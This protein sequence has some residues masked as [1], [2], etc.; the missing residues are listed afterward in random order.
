MNIENLVNKYGNKLN[1]G[2][3]EVDSTELYSDLLDMKDKTSEDEFKYKDT[4]CMLLSMIEHGYNPHSFYDTDI[5]ANAKR[6]IKEK[7]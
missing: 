6:L 2:E 1:S 3:L 5:I 7:Q 4:I